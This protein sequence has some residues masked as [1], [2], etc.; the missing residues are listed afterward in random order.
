MRPSSHK[1]RLNR[2]EPGD[3]LGTGWGCGFPCPVRPQPRRGQTP[4]PCLCSP[5]LLP[6]SGLYK[7][8]SGVLRPRPRPAPTGMCCGCRR[9]PQAHPPVAPSLLPQ[10]RGLLRRFP[11][12]ELQTLWSKSLL[13]TC[14]PRTGHCQAWG[15][16]PGKAGLILRLCLH[17]SLLGLVTPLPGLVYKYNERLPTSEQHNLY[18]TSKP[19]LSACS[20]LPLP[21]GCVRKP[22]PPGQS[23]GL[24][25]DKA[26]ALHPRVQR[27]PSPRRP[28]TC[29]RCCRR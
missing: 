26:N 18:E 8:P 21:P 17:S 4:A 9:P 6:A 28:G 15:C 12:T 24:R 19:I 5:P 13:P 2:P 27:D 23:L 16:C 25:A 3:P 20:E 7:V 22:L 11:S 29:T 10:L 1:C 14:A